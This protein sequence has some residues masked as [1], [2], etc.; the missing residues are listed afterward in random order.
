MCDRNRPFCRVRN[1]LFQFLISICSSLS[2]FRKKLISVLIWFHSSI[3]ILEI[4]NIPKLK[5]TIPPT[6]EWS[7]SITHNNSYVISLIFFIVGLS[8]LRIHHIFNKSVRENSL[9][10]IVNLRC[11]K[12]QLIILLSLEKLFLL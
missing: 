10:R 6:A 3:N 11:E 9:T 7:L 5:K 4:K 12:C 1:G 2:I 8:S